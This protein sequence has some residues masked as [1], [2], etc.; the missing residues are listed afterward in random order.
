MSIKHSDYICVWIYI[1]IFFCIIKNITFVEITLFEFTQPV[2]TRNEPCTSRR[3][4]GRLLSCSLYCWSWSPSTLAQTYEP[5]IWDAHQTLNKPL[6]EGQG[7]LRTPVAEEAFPFEKS[8]FCSRVSPVPCSPSKLLCKTIKTYRY[9]TNRSFQHGSLS[10]LEFVSECHYL[11]RDRSFW[12]V[13]QFQIHTPVEV[14][15]WDRVAVAVE[16]GHFERELNRNGHFVGYHLNSG[17]YLLGCS[18]T[19]WW[20]LW[21]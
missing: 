14:G 5:T 3:T 8:R 19:I 6:V 13:H 17:E 16:S 15:A 11:H 12:A 9:N 4:R 1:Y 10:A 2:G 20:V 21:F 18:V 7:V